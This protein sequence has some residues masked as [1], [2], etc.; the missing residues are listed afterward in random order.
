MTNSLRQL[1]RDISG[2]AVQ[3]AASAEE[4]TA[5]SEQT[6]K[7]TESIASVMQ[8]VA[9]GTDRQMESV[10]SSSN[11]ITE[12]GAAV[13]EAADSAAHAAGTAATTLIQ[14]E[15][16]KNAIGLSVTQMESI[17]QKVLGLSEVV[18]GLNERSG[19]IGS[20]VSLISDIA[21]QTNLLALNASIEAARVGEQGKGFAVVAGEVRKL[22]EQSAESGKKISE[23]I[24]FIQKETGG[25][26]AAM[27]ETVREVS[28][29]I[30]YVHTA[31]DKF[32]DI[33]EAVH[34]VSG[35]MERVSATVAQ[36]SAHTSQVAESIELVVEVAGETAQG[37]QNVS[38][39]T[40]EQLASMEEISA[41]AASLGHMAEQ[42]Q[43]L[44]SKFKI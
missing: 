12:M 3:L 29:G 30:R 11:L 35:H 31:G 17:H 41:S 4:L 10:S 5:G 8:D 26:A 13:R 19:E 1:I 39:A 7:A 44:I 32:T 22:A 6:G 37:S 43:G 34:D 42:L 20:I 27:D 33:H 36:I 9:A 16:G 2:S 40:E 23:L 28:D 25:A 24:A 15:E 21:A 14:T 38:A 18:S